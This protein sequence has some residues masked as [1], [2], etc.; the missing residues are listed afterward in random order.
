MHSEAESRNRDR[1]SKEG[2]RPKI[3][4]NEIEKKFIRWSEE[5]YEKIYKRKR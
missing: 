5:R 4:V 1:E 2:Q 3:R